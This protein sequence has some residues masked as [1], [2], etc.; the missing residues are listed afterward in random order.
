MSDENLFSSFQSSVQ[1]ALDYVEVTPGEVDYL[2]QPDAVHSYNITVEM[3]DG[4]IE[5]FPAHRVQFNDSLGPYKGGIRY[6]SSLTRDEV[7]ALA[8]RMMIKCA[9]VSLPFGGSKGGVQFEPSNYSIFE[10]ERITRAYARTIAPIIGTDTDIPAPDMKTNSRMMAWFRNE[11]EDIEGSQTPGIVTGKPVDYGGSVGREEATGRSV[12]NCSRA[13][14]NYLN[15][16]IEDATVAIQGFGNVGYHSA[17]LLA[18]EG[19]DIVSVSDSTGGIYQEEGLDIDAVLQAK[20][21]SGSVTEYED[22][23]QISNEELL[24]QSVDVLVPSAVGGAIDKQIA[25]QISANVVVEGANGP[26]TFDAENVLKDRD[27]IVVPGVI[28]N[29]GGVVVSYYEWVQNRQG[30]SWTYD[31]VISEFDRRIDD[32]LQEVIDVYQQLD[33]DTLR[34]AAYSIALSRILS[35]FRATR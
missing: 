15:E 21:Q 23:E 11:Y 26:V 31:R 35:S 9:T 16:D 29:S 2:T 10:I 32:S 17:R 5:S 1:N 25:E 7:K 33:L 4:S 12:M 22:A 13:M 19:A 14:L 6:D 18:A 30:Y 8:G 3:D 28:A 20:E 24:T 34:T 27:V